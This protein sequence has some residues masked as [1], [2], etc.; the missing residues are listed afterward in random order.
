MD[1]LMTVVVFAGLAFLCRLVSRAE[2]LQLGTEKI[3]RNG[4]TALQPAP[5]TLALLLEHLLS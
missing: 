5:R 1:L 4:G 2:L 3:W